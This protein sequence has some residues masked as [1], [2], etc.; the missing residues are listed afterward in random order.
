MSG[1]DLKSDVSY[2]LQRQEFMGEDRDGNDIYE[3]RK[4]ESSHRPY[5]FRGM[6]SWRCV[7]VTKTYEVVG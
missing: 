1:T 3:W 7:K 4:L 2:Q 5:D 6:T